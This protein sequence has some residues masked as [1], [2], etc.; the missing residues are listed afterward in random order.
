MGHDG[1]TPAAWEAR[2]A[3]FWATADDQQGDDARDRLEEILAERDDGDPVALFERASLHDFLGEETAAIP[4]YRAA[5]DAGL[6]GERRTQC[7]IQL[8]SSLRN[9]GDHSG[10]MALLGGIR[11][12]DPLGDAARAF[13]SLALH[14][15]SKPAPALRTALHALAPHLPRYG[16]AI[17]AYADELVAPRRIRVIAVAL[18]V[19]DGH[20]LAE[21]YRR[22]ARHEAFLRAPGGGIE[23]GEPAA[24]A[25]R[26]ELAEELGVE[27]DEATLLTVTENLYRLPHR[28]GHEIVYV[29]ATRSA[30][31]ETLPL[32]ARL[33]VRDSD[34]TVGWYRLDVLEAGDPPFYP[35]GILEL[36]RSLDRD[37]L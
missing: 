13:L 25:V 29:F 9:V 5:L 6:C 18:V 2:L 28:A 23:F 31:L 3:H 35:D 30:A 15:D 7:V 12:D 14:D 24:E 27:V 34:T 4:L 17:D 33:P 1:T 11:P 20:V 22:T 16:R 36:A 19:R 37:A 32:D 8:A 21:E 26:R 10:A